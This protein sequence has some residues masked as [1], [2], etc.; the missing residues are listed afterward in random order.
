MGLKHVK[1]VFSLTERQSY[2]SSF[3]LFPMFDFLQIMILLEY[4]RYFLGLKVYILY[5]GSGRDDDS[6]LFCV[7]DDVSCVVYYVRHLRLRNCL[8]I[9]FLADEDAQN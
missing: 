7:I 2:D 5:F 6:L 4:F 9:L 3:F 8:L 1:L